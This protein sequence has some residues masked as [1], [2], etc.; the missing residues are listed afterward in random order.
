MG[1]VLV[2][3]YYLNKRIFMSEI[4]NPET[5][6]LR[7]TNPRHCRLLIKYL[8][9]ANL[10]GIDIKN[11]QTVI[12]LLKVFLQAY[13][14]ESSEKMEKAIAEIECKLGITESQSA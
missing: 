13:E 7:L 3:N 2:F 10:Q 5:G 1:A 11:G 12:G 4:Y 8:I 14:A 9:E 6:K